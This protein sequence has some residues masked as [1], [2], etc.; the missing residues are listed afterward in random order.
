MKAYFVQSM[1]ERGFLASTLFYAMYAHHESHVD[2]YID[3]VGRAFSEIVNLE[4]S[5][6]FKSK[7]KGQPATSGFKRIA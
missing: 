4:Q 6:S 7:L 1:L 2:K 3:A 5:G